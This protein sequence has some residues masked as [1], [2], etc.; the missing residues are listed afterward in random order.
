MAKTPNLW[1]NA[2]IYAAVLA[3]F[4]AALVCSALASA[5]TYEATG[6]VNVR[7]GP[8][9]NH[10]VL[11]SLKQ[12]ERV[13]KLGAEGRYIKVRTESGMEGYVWESLLAGVDQEG[14]EAPRFDALSE[15]LAQGAL[16]RIKPGPDRYF[17]ESTLEFLR[18]ENHGVFVMIL[19]LIVA[20]VLAVLGAWL[21]KLAYKKVEI[22]I[23]VGIGRS[24]RMTAKL[25]IIVAGAYLIIG[26]VSYFLDLSMHYA[27][28]EENTVLV[29]ALSVPR[30]ILAA[31]IAVVDA[32]SANWVA[33]LA[34]ILLL[35]LIA[36]PG[37]GAGDEPAEFDDDL[38]TA[39]KSAIEFADG[40]VSDMPEPDES[41]TVIKPRVSS[42]E[43]R[44]DED[45]DSETRIVADE[46]EGPD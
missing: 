34:F 3:L 27:S 16:T 38:A 1:N 14:I 36:R 12:G 2:R 32:L 40:G 8:G 20:V 25:I 29:I 42:L 31:P 6:S 15:S 7:Q 45:R 9:G 17:F 18:I 33:G 26:A 43:P 30:L 10:P 5:E 44:E 46:E 23:P 39:V 22:I 13:E 37:L 24:R 21:L 4:A 19:P 28:L 41:D 35:V 11:T